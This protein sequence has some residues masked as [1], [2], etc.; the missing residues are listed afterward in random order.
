MV[1]GQ[2][3]KLPPVYLYPRVMTHCGIKRAFKCDVLRDPPIYGEL[4]FSQE[5]QRNEASK[6][7]R[8]KVTI[9]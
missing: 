9:N 4:Y 6:F 1:T 3:H 2:L 8:E 5:Y 7:K